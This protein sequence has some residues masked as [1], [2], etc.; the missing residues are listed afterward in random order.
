ERRVVRIVGLG[1]VAP[2]EAERVEAARDLA[3]LDQVLVAAARLLGRRAAAAEIRAEVLQVVPDVAAAAVLD[4]RVDAVDRP[5]IV[6]VE[7]G[8]KDAQAP[9]L[10]PALVRIDVVR[11]VAARAGVAILADDLARHVATRERA[12]RAAAGP[13]RVLQP[14]LDVGHLDRPLLA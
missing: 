14:L 8:G 6:G 9:Q 13:R 10:A 2:P 7:P 3:A 5:R 12:D 1:P 11:I 4:I